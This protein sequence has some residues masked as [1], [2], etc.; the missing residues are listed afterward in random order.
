MLS[1]HLECLLARLSRGE[2]LD[3]DEGELLEELELQELL[4]RRVDVQ[5]RDDKVEDLL[6]REDLQDTLEVTEEH[7]SICET[8]LAES[9]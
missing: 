4:L 2:E 7:L 3:E 6:I 8:V 5:D 9:V 1:T